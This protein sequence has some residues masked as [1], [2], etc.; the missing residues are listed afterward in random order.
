[1]EKLKW[2]LQNTIFGEKTSF[3][4]VDKNISNLPKIVGES[5]LTS[6]AKMPINIFNKIL[7]IISAGTK[8][9]NF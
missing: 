1:M 5:L 3:F 2:K 9:Y 8:I 4:L 6:S 7:K